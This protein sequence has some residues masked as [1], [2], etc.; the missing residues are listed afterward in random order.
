MGL[1]QAKSLWPSIVLGLVCDIRGYQTLKSYK[2]LFDLSSIRN[3]LKKIPDTFVGIVSKE[4]PYKVWEY[5]INPELI[6]V[7]F[8][9]LKYISYT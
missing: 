7:L 6:W 1:S 2:G 4:I 5:V 3:I 8:W 9:F